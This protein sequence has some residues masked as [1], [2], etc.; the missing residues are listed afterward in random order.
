MFGQ[1]GFCFQFCDVA[2]LTDHHPQEDLATFW[3]P[4][5]T[6]CRNMASSSSLIIWGIRV[7]FVFHKNP[8]YV[9][10]NHPGQKHW[11]II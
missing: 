3:L 8:L 9:F 5:G 11:L 1:T 2:K 7:L 6:C 10:K 4:F